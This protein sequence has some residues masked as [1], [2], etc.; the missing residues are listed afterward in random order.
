MPSTMHTEGC[1]GPSMR[2]SSDG[3]LGTRAKNHARNQVRVR[4][5]LH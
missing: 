4:A 5:L 1:V 3:C 2:T